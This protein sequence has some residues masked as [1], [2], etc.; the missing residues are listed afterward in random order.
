MTRDRE[1]YLLRNIKRERK[2]ERTRERERER[3]RE[4]KQSH[5]VEPG[6]A[7]VIIPTEIKICS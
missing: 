3:E 4:R 6:N 5:S 2:G 1:R 7:A